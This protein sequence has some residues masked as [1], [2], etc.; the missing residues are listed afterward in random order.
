M[1]FDEKSLGSTPTMVGGTDGGAGRSDKLRDYVSIGST[2]TMAGRTA[3]LRGRLRPGDSLLG[4]YTVLAELGEGG[5]GVVYKC[6]DTVGGIEVAVKCLPPEL[7]RNEAEMEG[8]RENYAIVARLHHSAISGLRQLEKDPDFGEYYLVMDLARGEDLSTIL[9]R[10]RGS[11][12]S[13]DEALAILRPLAAALDYAHGEK[14]LHRDVKPGNVKVETLVAGKSH[15]ETQRHKEGGA[16]SSSE[17]HVQLLDFG[18][19]AEVRSSMS[20]VSLRGHVGSS[21]TPAYMAPEQWE[22]RRQSAATDQYSLAVMAYQML[23]GALP[24]DADDQ[25]LLRRAVLSRPPDPVAELPR[26]ANAALLRALAKDPMDRFPSCQAFVE[27]LAR[28]LGGAGAAG[29]RRLWPW[30]AALV[31]A[32]AVG[33]VLWRNGGTGATGATG[34]TEVASSSPVALVAPVPSPVAPVPE[35]SGNLTHQEIL[36]SPALPEPPAPALPPDG[37]SLE[38]LQAARDR[39][40]D[41]LEARRAEGWPDDSA[42]SAPLA[43]LIATLDGRI[44]SA[45]KEREEQERQSERERIE[46]RASD[47]RAVAAIGRLKAAAVREVQGVEKFRKWNDGEFK[48]QFALLDRQKAALD[49]FSEAS[50]LAEAKEAAADIHSA[51]V[52]IADNAEAREG[53]DA[54]EKAIDALSPELEKAEAQCYAQSALYAANTARKEAVRRRDRSDFTGAKEKFEEAKRLFDGA[55]AEARRTQASAKAREA[56]GEAEEAKIREDWE[57]VL[58]KA[59]AALALDADNADAKNLKF[60]AQAKL[61]AI[62][63]ELE[64]KASETAHKGRA[65]SSDD[66][67]ISTIDLGGGVSLEMVHC[68]GVSSDFWMGKYEVTQEQWE[69]VMDNNP[70]YFKGAGNPVESVSWNDCQEF[71]RKLNALPGARASGLTFRLPTER[72]WE[73]ACRAGAPQ[74]A[75]Y[76]KLKDGTQIT[77]WTLSRVA[78]YGKGWD[79][80]T[81]KVGSFEPNAWGLYDMHGNVCELTETAGGYRRVDRG[82]SF[83]SGAEYCSAGSRD[84]SYLGNSGRFLGFRLAASGRAA[85]V[86]VKPETPVLPSDGKRTAQSVVWESANERKV[87]RVGSQEIAL[88]WCPATTSEEWKR[89]SG[90]KDF[91]MMGSPSSEEG[92]EDNETQHRVTLT[93]GFWMGETEVTQGLWKEVMGNNPSYFENN[94][95]FGGYTSTQHPVETVSWDDC[96]EF[97]KKLNAR[98]PQSGLRWTLPTETQWEYACRAGTTGAYGGTGKLDDMGW[99]NN[100]I[101]GGRSTH[102]VKQK[103]PNAWGLYDMH[104]NVWEWCA[105]WYDNY[106]SGT[107]TDSTGPS[108]GLFRVYRGGSWCYYARYCRSAYRFRR[109]PHARDYFLGFRIALV[110]VQ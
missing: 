23:S 37:A 6:L 50:D 66:P 48:A 64:R 42:E 57:T 86:S 90:G 36:E 46:K 107:V 102:P 32:F 7:S 54:I 15:T 44:T 25:D 82:G 22:A 100:G 62:K 101:R 58:A 106:P 81:V 56:V 84:W 24:F 103:Q 92:R 94:G 20:R 91:F 59:N 65:S 43:E 68:P 16:T 87:V 1:D 2:T 60:E 4:R 83:L 31:A 14:V 63:A 75:D 33:A 95:E 38:E 28:G 98:S 96:Q 74:S 108:T 105:D 13:P 41:A 85:I 55:L 18:L 11:P 110:P 71:I 34:A 19:A 35:T 89:I 40:A 39:L 88:R 76:C 79:D 27:A 10:R 61:A 9:R 52:W 3:P 30:A 77:A 12:M 8:I 99:Y 51:A 93:K 49:G 21:G 104:G 97:L 109:L 67:L 73:T 72:E 5:M 78:R 80:G 53:L 47:A 29:L 45:L 26:A 70:S 69:R 17:P